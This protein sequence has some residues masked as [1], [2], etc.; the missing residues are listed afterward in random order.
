[1]LLR[2]ATG[3]RT[4]ILGRIFRT[5]QCKGRAFTPELPAR[6]RHRSLGLL[7]LRLHEKAGRKIARSGRIVSR[8]TALERAATVSRK[9][10]APSSREIPSSKPKEGGSD[11][12]EFED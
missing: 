7:R 10:Q 1:M 9:P 11:S 2:S 4:T 12:L 6:K 3:G 8:N 5:H